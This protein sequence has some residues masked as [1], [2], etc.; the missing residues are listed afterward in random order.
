[1]DLALFYYLLLGFAVLMYVVLDGFD[2]GLGILYPW[3][4]SEAER[5]HMMRSISHVW[6]GNETWLVFGGVVL[7]A[8][9]PAAYAGILATLYTPIIIML[10]GLI[11][12]G[13][14]F[15]YRFK[16][17]RSK[18]W[19]DLSF[20]LGSTVATFCQGAILGA[21]VQ[22]VEAGPGE[23]GALEWLSPFSIFTGF[24]LMVAYALLACC[25]LV[26]KS[27]GD[28]MARAAHLGRQLVLAIMA[29]LVVVSLWTLLA[30]TEVRTRWLDGLN[31]LW[32]SPL[33]LLSALFGWLLYRDLD[34]QPHETRPFWLAVGLFLLGFI[35]L[36]VGLFPYLIPH[37]M[38]LWDARAPDSSL[39][40]LLPG[41]FIFLPLIC[42]YTLWGYR[43][44]SGKV[45]DFEE[46]Y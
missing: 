11:F 7:F 36:V 8:A 38:T 1:M 20:F 25:Y 41:I 26:M 28:I 14:A 6:D 5:D 4:K 12:R 34:G 22:G 27:R 23:L 40:F 43:I 39:L 13:V 30:N 9:F 15:E 46:G 19:W 35:G 3:F 33:P 17:H 24:A 10:I 37:Q 2:L 31:F 21:V 16:S 44:F 42:A 18:P 45:E 32:L 29:I